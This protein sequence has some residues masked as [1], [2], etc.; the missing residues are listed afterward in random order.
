MAS[1]VNGRPSGPR[2]CAPADEAARGEPDVGGDDDVTRARALG[3]PVV[4]IVELATRDH[5]QLD[6]RRERHLHPGVRHDDDRHPQPPCDAI[7]LLLHRTGV[8]IDEDSRHGQ[9]GVLAVHP[10]R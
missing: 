9:A 8:G 6:R 10:D 7:D 1:S 3:N 2:A 5:H 4:D